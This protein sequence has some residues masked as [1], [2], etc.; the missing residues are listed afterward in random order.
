VL[1]ALAA[2]YS[3]ATA[4]DACEEWC[5]AL[6]VLTFNNAVNQRLFGT[7][8]VRDALV[9]LQPQVT[10]ADA[11]Y[12][13]CNAIYNLTSNKSANQQLLG[14]AEVRDALVAL[15]PLVSTAPLCACSGAPRSPIW[16]SQILLGSMKRNT[17]LLSH[18]TRSPVVAQP[19]QRAET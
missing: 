2:L 13:W 7:A 17:P 8:A 1:A 9:A 19:Q 4:P 14:T 6:A 11:C 3:R 18:P 12:W 16:R 15:R 5:R 10:T